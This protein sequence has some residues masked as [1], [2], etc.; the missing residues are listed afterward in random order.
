MFLAPHPLKYRPLLVSIF[1]AIALTTTIGLVSPLSTQAANSP[2]AQLSTQEQTTL[3]SGRVS[4]TGENGR[5]TCRVLVTAPVAIVWKLLTDYN[6]FENYFPNVA[7]SQILEAKGNRKV[8]EQVYLIQAL[9]FSKRSRVRIASTET[10]PRQIDFNLV[11]GDV[12]ALKGT[13]RLE[14]VSSDRV[15]VTH[16]VTVDPG[17]DNRALF[18]GIYEDTLEKTLQAVKQRSEQQANRL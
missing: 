10:Y 18:F 17:S 14:P 8:F 6:N 4:L 11:E 9:I 12:N 1:S 16:Q 3:R 2:I 5:Y 7:S 15:L 13:W